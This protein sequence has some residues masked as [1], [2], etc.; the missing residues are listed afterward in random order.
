MAANQPEP[1]GSRRRDA[2][3]L[4]VALAA[5][6]ALS[7][8]LLTSF[9]VL[10]PD[11]VAELGLSYGQAGM[12]GAAYMLGYGLFQVPLGLLAT[13]LGAGRVLLAATLLMALSAL[14]PCLASGF[15]V[16]LVARLLSGIAAGAVLPLGL[17]LLMHA[18]S[19]PGLVRGIGVFVSGWG[20]GMTIAMLGAAPLLDMAGW[21]QVMMAVAAFGLLVAASLPFALPKH[22]A[23]IVRSAAQPTRISALLLELGRNRALN[24]MALINAAGTTT[25]VCIPAWLPLYLTSAFAVPP[26]TASAQLSPIGIGVATGAWLGGALASRLGWRPVVIASFVLSCG[27]VALI[28]MQASAL[29]VAALAILVGFAGMLFPAPIQSLFP[30]VVPAAQTALAAAYYNTIGFIGAFAASLL[31][32]FLVERSGS[33]TIGWLLLAIVP[34]AGIVS[35]LLLP[36]A[37]LIDTRTKA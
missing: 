31:F 20:I 37:G 18:L 22:D 27:L 6:F 28:P 2:R 26:A 1:A 12:V 10:L 32:G 35:A 36:I 15:A 8:T 30:M 9:A 24:L 16:W 21:R 17:H 33:F 5:C 34:L 29:V 19:G 3:R 7:S 11:I 14:L 25:M 23:G 13:S 4:P